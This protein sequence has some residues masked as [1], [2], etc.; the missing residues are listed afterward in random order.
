LIGQIAHQLFI[1]HASENCCIFKISEEIADWAQNSS[2]ELQVQ[3][4]FRS[5]TLPANFVI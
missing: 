2:F 1:F 5:L 3:N 4:T